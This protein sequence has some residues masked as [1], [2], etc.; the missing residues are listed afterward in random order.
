MAP[1]DSETAG[2]PGAGP[3]APS[4]GV[5][6]HLTWYVGLLLIALPL[7]GFFDSFATTFRYTMITYVRKDFGVSFGEFVN[8]FTWV[9]L[10]SCLAF[11][12]RVLADVFGRRVMLWITTAGLCFLQW[13]VGLA[14]TPG[15]YIALMTLLA[16]FYKSD[17]WLLVISEEAPPRHRG[18]CAAITV[19]PAA[20][21][22]LVLGELVRRMGDE[23]GA[24]REV[25]RFPIWGVIA[26]IPLFFLVRETHHFREGR[27]D[28]AGRRRRR[29]LDL[30]WMPFR[31]GLI[32]PLL[33]M[34]ALKM[35]FT[36]G[37][38]V[39]MALLGTEYLRVDNG[40]GPEVVGRVVQME[41]GAIMAAWVAAGF[42]S[43]RIGR[44][45]SLY[46]FGGLYIAALLSLALL[47]KGST[48]VIAAYV[49][50]I[51]AGVAVFAI[52]RVATMELF[53]NECRSIGTAWTDLFMTV[54][55][56]VTARL[57]GWVTASTIRAEHG[58]SLS[59][60][61][62]A[63]ALIVP[64]VLPLFSLLRETRGQALEEV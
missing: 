18:L 42:L 17:I 16:V 13:L 20:C 55:A 63:L 19:A 60:C 23:Q 59:A 54:F 2:T 26:S 6:G 7:A 12:P 45:V 43:D 39:A 33:V 28:P 31:S 64:L 29:R 47:P 62:I 10:G 37:V 27:L 4:T 25:A 32:R 9:Y 49:T 14:R 21:G 1:S 57:L 24:W 8:L 38:V 56:A 5:P 46:L 53:P 61:I 30:V 22:A 11:V 48:F 41:V 35:L 3:D 50:Q 44:H 52:L 34:S 40:F 36:G 15:E 58:V 51:F